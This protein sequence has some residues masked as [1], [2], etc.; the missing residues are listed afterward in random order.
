[1]TCETDLRSPS[2]GAANERSSVIEVDGL[3]KSYG[4]ATVVDGVS[5]QVA[6]GEIFGLLGANGAGKTTTVECLQGLRPADDGRLRVLGLDPV[7]DRKRLRSLIGS[8][9]QDCALPDRLRVG[10]ALSLFDRTGRIDPGL[11]LETWGLTSSIGTPFAALSGGQKQRLFIVL[12]L[13]NQPK[14]VFLDELTQG[15]DPAARR[16]VWQVVR[17]VRDQGT[18][19]VVVSHFADEVEAL[20]DR[21]AVMAHGQI[22]DTGTSRDLIDRHGAPTVVS[23]TAPISFDPDHIRRLPGVTNVEGLRDQI[24]VTGTSAMVAPVCAATLDD[25][26]A[27]PADLHVTHPNLNDALVNLIGAHP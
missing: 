18:T 15:L 7:A 24:Q 6:D 25:V 5:L 13:L 4:R 22:V 16:D 11:Y 10:E 26:G 14:V 20:C 3:V 19:V 12:A 1:M 27:G 17:K 8:Q 9:L 2:P 23:F 21:V